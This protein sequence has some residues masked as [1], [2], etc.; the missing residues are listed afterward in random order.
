MKQAKE[1]K[2][3]DNQL[4]SKKNLDVNLILTCNISTEVKLI[5]WACV[6][7]RVVICKWYLVNK[8]GHG[9]KCT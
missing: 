4:R 2:K 5:T 7:A 1:T 6:A 9:P 8:R 3:I